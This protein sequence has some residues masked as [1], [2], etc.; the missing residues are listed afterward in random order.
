VTEVR[1]PVATADLVAD[2]RVARR[3]IGDAQQRL[4]QAHQ[5]HALL[6]RQRELLHQALD[7]PAARLGAERDDEAASEVAHGIPPRRRQRRGLEQRGQAVRLGASVRGGD[8][9]A[10]RRLAQGSGREGGEGAGQVE[11]RCGRGHAL[12][13]GRARRNGQTTLSRTGTLLRVALLYG[14]TW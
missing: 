12:K 2:Q 9:L 14:Q 8:G 13:I 11:E 6:R 5:R 7:R 3:G 4:G 1:A 10:Q